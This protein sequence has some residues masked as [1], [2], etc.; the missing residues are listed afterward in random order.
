MWHV[1][2]SD[3]AACI[4]K[5]R[6]KSPLETASKIYE[7][8]KKSDYD[9]ILSTISGNEI[10][11]TA[12][13]L[14]TSL[15]IT[16]NVQ[17][18]VSKEN[19]EERG[20]TMKII[21]D[22]L[23]EKTSEKT[24][25]K[26]IEKVTKAV[27][28]NDEESLENVSKIIKELVPKEKEGL[29]QDLVE[30]V[31]KKVSVATTEEEREKIMKSMKDTI[32]KNQRKKLTK[33][34]AEKVVNSLVNTERGTRDEEKVVVDIEK[35][36][37]EKVTSKNNIFYKKR[38]VCFDDDGKEF[39]Y[40][41]GGK[42]DGIQGSG[43]DRILVE[44]KN[45]QKRLFNFVPEYDKIQIYAYMFLTGISKANLVESFNGESKTHSFEFDVE[46]WNFIETRLTDFVKK[47][48]EISNDE[49]KKVLLVKQDTSL[50]GYFTSRI[51][52]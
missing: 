5:S 13:N 4:S 47:L 52:F 2:A 46:Y 11:E 12:K 16:K 15:D 25:V 29:I 39:V 21:V 22:D 48:E 10:I 42:I 51:I 27:T 17:L 44:V 6:F 28:S 7:K 45:R 41:I 19:V 14:K 24:V 9:E 33:N 40:T 20:K 36:T 37:Q 31:K 26:N 43:K 50:D 23:M 38:I 30:D 3:I 34:D 35:K 18:A 49:E 8:C 32:R 1:N